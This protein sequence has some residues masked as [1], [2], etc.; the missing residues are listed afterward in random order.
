[1]KCEFCGLEPVSEPELEELK[2]YGYHL[3]CQEQG[4]EGVELIRKIRQEEI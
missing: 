2:K 4:G 3:L 1:M